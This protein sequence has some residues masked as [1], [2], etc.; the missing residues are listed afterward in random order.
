MFKY[1][2][3]KCIFGMC[4]MLEI[5]EIKFWFNDLIWFPYIY[6][7]YTQKYVVEN[8]IEEKNKIYIFTLITKKKITILSGKFFY[9]K[10]LFFPISFLNPFYVHS[11]FL[12]DFFLFSSIR[13]SKCYKFCCRWAEYYSCSFYYKIKL[14]IF[15]F[16]KTFLHW[17]TLKIIN[18]LLTLNKK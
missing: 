9:P 12:L 5:A 18:C 14:K 13:I 6:R 4:L 10:C 17:W 2:Q 1:F 7:T 3:L 8:E 11:T 15:L 16:Y